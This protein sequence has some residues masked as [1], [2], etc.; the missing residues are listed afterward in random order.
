MVTRKNAMTT[1]LIAV[2]I[3]ASLIV[4]FT[5]ASIQEAEAQA[6]FTRRISAS[7]VETSIAHNAD[8]HS[9]HQVVHFFN[10]QQDAIYNG[11]VTFTSSKGVDIIAYHDI[12]G[13]NATGLKTWKVDGR[14]YGITT[15]LTNATSGTVDF[16]GAGILAHS[17]ASDPYTVV[18]TVDGLAKKITPAAR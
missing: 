15:V 17:A 11:K 9:A 7:F 3:T 6:K 14:T 13:H 16:V 1:A 10:P 8:G 2:A 5:A 4:A 18:Y 12:T